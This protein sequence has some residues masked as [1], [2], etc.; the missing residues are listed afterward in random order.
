TR[1]ERRWLW[2]GGNKEEKKRRP[3]HRKFV[4]AY[5]GDSVSDYG[6]L[7]S[8]HLGV[9]LRFQRQSVPPSSQ[10]LTSINASIMAIYELVRHGK[11]ALA[12]S[13]ALYL[14]MLVYALQLVQVKIYSDI[15]GPFLS[16][17]SFIFFHFLYVIP[18]AIGVSLSGPASPNVFDA[19]PAPRELGS[20]T[21]LRGIV[22]CT[23]YLTSLIC[24]HFILASRDWFQCRAFDARATNSPG[25]EQPN[26]WSLYAENYESS[27]TTILLFGN[28]LTAANLLN[29]G[30]KWRQPWYKNISLL[31]LTLLL[32]VPWVVVAVAPPNFLG[33]LLE[34][35]CGN[36][37]ALARLGY[38]VPAGITRDYSN[39]PS[40]HNVLPAGFRAFLLAYV[41]ATFGATIFVEQFMIRG[42][43]GRVLT[44]WWGQLGASK[45][46]VFKP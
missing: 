27:V 23:I 5:V 1:P 24:M 29:L 13:Y 7:D 14:Y 8:A 36:P 28:V 12:T 38:R 46:H 45:L 34:V 4:F 11:A 18:L 40:G 44:N 43:V 22:Y 6:G 33:C 9:L 37:E 3:K 41:A 39:N 26:R 15:F 21:T 16:K 19:A 10:V 31:C 32:G 35:N 25:W 30:D 20:L 17:W 42:L 2:W